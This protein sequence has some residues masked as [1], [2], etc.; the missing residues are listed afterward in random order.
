MGSFIENAYY[1]DE[2]TSRN[3]TKVLAGK[4]SG[5]S[6][7]VDVNNKL[8]PA[9][10][11]VEKTEITDLE[12]KKIKEQASRACGGVDQECIKSTETRL[13]QEKLA[14]KDRTNRQD[15]PNIK[16]P[17]L[18][19]NV[20]DKDGKRRRIVVPDGQTFKLDNVVASK[21]AKSLPPF[22]YFQTQ[23][24]TLAG[25]IVASLVYVFGVLATYTVF[26]PRYGPFIAGP[27]TIISVFVPYSGYFMI[28]FYFMFFKAVDI[29]TGK[30]Q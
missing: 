10:E 26:S 2:K 15:N 5:T 8:I 21:D 14:E 17:R 30:Q 18:T 1:G 20:I 22:Q 6:L 3:V 28:F 16:G 25:I 23:F 7:N 13:R 9:F 4:I 19:V 24:L 29:Y 27:L 11:V 12:D